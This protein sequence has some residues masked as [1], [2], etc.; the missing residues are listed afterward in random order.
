VHCVTPV[1]LQTPDF[2]AMKEFLQ[3]LRFLA[4]ITVLE[5]LINRKHSISRMEAK[6][7]QAIKKNG[8]FH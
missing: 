6:S 4:W 8:I 1:L 5:H 3:I 2:C 7:V